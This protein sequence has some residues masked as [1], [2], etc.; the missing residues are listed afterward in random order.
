MITALDTNVLLD[1][2]LPNENFYDASAAALENAASEGSLVICDVVYAELCAHF[3]T[4]RECGEFLKDTDIRVES[5]GRGACF[6]ASRT[7]R[8]YRLHG[9]KRSRILPDFLIGA[10]AQVHAA[11]LLSRDR[12]FYRES[13]PS[14]RLIDP[15][16]REN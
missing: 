8:T 7:W 3:R 4:E 16:A 9:G 2:L 13:F 1:I 6:L 10:H 5:L 15:A 14:L 11:R 12:G